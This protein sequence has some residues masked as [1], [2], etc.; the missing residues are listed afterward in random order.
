MEFKPKSND[1]PDTINFNFSIQ[2]SKPPSNAQSVADALETFGS[3]L[4]DESAAY[5]HRFVSFEV[6]PLTTT[7]VSVAVARGSWRQLEEATHSSSY[8]AELILDKSFDLYASEMD[9]EEVKQF[10]L[11][12]VVGLDLEGLLGEWTAVGYIPIATDAVEVPVATTDAVEEAPEN[13]PATIPTTAPDV[14]PVKPNPNASTVT[15]ESAAVNVVD[16]S[17]GNINSNVLGIFFAVV[18]GC[19]AAFV[20]AAF[21]QNRKRRKNNA[22]ATETSV[23]VDHIGD[24]NVREF[25][26]EKP[27][28][29]VGEWAAGLLPSKSNNDNTGSSPAAAA[30][31]IDRVLAELHDSED[32]SFISAGSSGEDGS[33]FSGYTGMTGISD[34]NYQPKSKG[35]ASTL[36]KVEEVKTSISF[37]DKSRGSLLRNTSLNRKKESFESD[38]SDSKG[39]S[40]TSQSMRKEESFES[41]YRD[42]SAMATL[43]LKK[44]MLNTDVGEDEKART[45][46]AQQNSEMLAQQ[47]QVDKVRAAT[48]KAKKR[49]KSIGSSPQKDG[50]QS[51]IPNSDAERDQLLPSPVHKSDDDHVSFEIV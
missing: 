33:H 26:S 39:S 13:E 27:K 21:V 6:D 41:D 24:V 46:S 17:A 47:R 12:G 14:V 4:F 32:S 50:S 11:N 22:T 31:D 25:E 18:G 29:T 34:L 35:D 36:E 7:S 40:R 23:E 43:N 45:M 20:F 28:V 19:L 37:L 49:M 9:E 1:D 5:G 3:T 42:K 8:E 44:D 10:F 16:E 38:P 51:S 30:T 48:V 15:A 2:S